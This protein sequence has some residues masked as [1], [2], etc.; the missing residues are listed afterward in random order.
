M[1]VLEIHHFLDRAIHLCFLVGFHA[2]EVKLIL[3]HVARKT[4]VLIHVTIF[5]KQ[6]LFAVSEVFIN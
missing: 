2:L 6:E 1:S 5:T 4:G 3:M